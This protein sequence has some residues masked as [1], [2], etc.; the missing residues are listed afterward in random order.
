MEKSRNSYFR[1]GFA[2]FIS[3]TKQIEKIGGE[4]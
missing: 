2:L 1:S 4:I 3:K